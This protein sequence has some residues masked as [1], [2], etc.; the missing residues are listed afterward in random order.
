MFIDN[1]NENLFIPDASLPHSPATVPT[2]GFSKY[3]ESSY[4]LMKLK[5]QW[6]EAEKH[7]KM[8]K[9][10][11]ASILDPYSNAFAWMQMQTFNE[12]VWIGLNSNL[13]RCGNIR[14]LTWLI[15]CDWIWFSSCSFCWTLVLCKK[16]CQGMWMIQTW[17]RPNISRIQCLPGSNK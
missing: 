2:D 7:C 3:G 17:K 6:Y 13:V 11:V 12:P 1:A 15:H 10:L 16:L 4:S 5:L 9:S 14:H 8:Q